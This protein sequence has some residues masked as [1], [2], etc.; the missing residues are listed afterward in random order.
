MGI[1]LMCFRFEGSFGA[2]VTS[3]YHSFLEDQVRK[4]RSFMYKLHII[5]T[6]GLTVG[7]SEAVTLACTD[8]IEF[9]LVKPQ[10]LLHAR[11]SR[12]SRLHLQQ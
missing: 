2:S 8:Q 11:P 3:I 10:N 5:C 9:K 4:A 6:A 12:M 7:C 1:L